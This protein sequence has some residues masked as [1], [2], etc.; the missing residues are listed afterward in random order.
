[1]PVLIDTSFLLALTIST[2]ANHQA[3]RQ[4]AAQLQTTEVLPIPVMPKV[5]QI[6]SARGYY[7]AAV[8]LYNALQTAG[9]Q[10]EPITLADRLRMGEIMAAY[11]QTQ[12]DFTDT[13]I[14]AIGERLNIRQICSFNTAVFS[15]YR[16][17]HCSQFELIP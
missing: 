12:F 11:P 5:F 17:V 13:S 9:F 7:S 1:M 10:V 16:P 4:V 14:M 8:K 3:A 15:I 2:D 6:L